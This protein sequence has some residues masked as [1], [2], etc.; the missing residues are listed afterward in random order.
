MPR[1]AAKAD[2]EMA[3]GARLVSNSFPFPDRQPDAVVDV[4]DR[5]H[6]RLHVYELQGARRS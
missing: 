4:A 1:L 2:G 5:R 6:T 3:P